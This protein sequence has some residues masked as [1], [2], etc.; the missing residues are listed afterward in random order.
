MSENDTF[1]EILNQEI[2]WPLLG[3][4]PFVPSDGLTSVTIPENELPRFYMMLIGYEEAAN[5]LV[6]IALENRHRREAL[7]FPILFLYRHYIELQLKYF[8]STY[9][10]HAG[11]EPVWKTHDLTIL[12]RRFKEILDEFVGEDQGP[13]DA[14]TTVENIVA[15]FAKMDPRSFSYRY[16]CDKKGRPVP[17]AYNN[18]DLETLKDVMDGLS[19]YFGGCEGYFDN[20]VSAEPHP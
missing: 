9:G 13:D 16:P 17:I 15:Q 3:D 11:I 14:D 6:D 10:R 7:I 5:H 19:A 18:L 2:R 1:A 4:N 20:L 8:I 12:W